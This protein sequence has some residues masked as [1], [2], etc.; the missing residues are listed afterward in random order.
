MNELIVGLL[1]AAVAWWLLTRRKRAALAPA[2]VSILPERFVVFDL[3]T[4]GLH[5]DRHEI[6]EI[7]AIRVDRDADKHQTFQTLVKP[8]KLQ[9]KERSDQS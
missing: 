9:Q 7:G 4:T 8:K 5:P 3:E 2:D 6:I 1:L